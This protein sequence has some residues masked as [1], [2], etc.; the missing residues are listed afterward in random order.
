VNIIHFSAGRINPNAAKVGS[1]NVIY[2]LATEQARLGY[3]VIVVVIPSKLDYHN[4][5]AAKFN[6]VE[7]RQASLKGFVIPLRLVQDIINGRLNMNVAHLHAVFS[8]EMFT[9]SR[10]LK[11]KRTPYVISSHG[12]FSHLIFKHNPFLKRVYQRIFAVPYVN[13]AMF[14]HLHSKEEVQDA[15]KF[16]VISPTVIAE[17]GFD[18]K[19]IPQEMDESWLNKKYPQHKEALKLVFLGRLDPWHKGLD[20]LLEAFGLALQRLSEPVALFIIGP[21]KKRYSGY[22]QNLV[23]KLGLLKYVI[24]TGAIY[25]SVTK[26]SALASADILVLTS[27]FEGFPLV[28]L[29][30]MACG[31][32]VLVTPGT[33]VADMVNKYRVGFVCNLDC[34]A[35]A[36][37]ITQAS[38]K[39]GHLNAIG[40]HAQEIVKQFS[41]QKTAVK[42]V[43]S[44]SAALK[45]RL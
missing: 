23:Q 19:T 37:T 42:L 26:Y 18:L 41:W 32:P 24:F 4:I 31:T 8:P 20:L 44:Y 35:I 45:G 10:V 5:N 6:I 39:R 21:E 25:D 14:V 9:I 3:N 38:H 1:A 12:S 28:V 30:A 27:R 11:L 16:G 40:Q 34:S 33:N 43:N 13:E 29:E 36:E 15:K 2:N 17:Q 7:Y 22:L